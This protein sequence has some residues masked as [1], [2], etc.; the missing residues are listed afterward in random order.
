VPQRPSP[1]VFDGG[2][3]LCVALLLELRQF[4]TGMPAGTD[5]HVIATD[6]AAPL[7]LPAWCHL[8]GHAYLGPVPGR[9]SR[10][11]LRLASTPPPIAGYRPWHDGAS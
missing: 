11:A 1:Q 10:F 9:P 7:D 5:I 8:T 3:R 2:E 6:P 4:I